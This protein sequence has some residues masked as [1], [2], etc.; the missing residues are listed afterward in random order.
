MVDRGVADDDVMMQSYLDAYH[1][2][3]DS[4]TCQSHTRA[5]F[6]LDVSFQFRK[7]V[8]RVAADRLI[9]GK[10]FFHLVSYN[11]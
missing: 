10:L 6:R 8:L 3:C 9:N 1:G 4:R 5:E 7:A 2:T 11:Y